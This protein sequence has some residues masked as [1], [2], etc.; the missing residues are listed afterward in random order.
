[1][2]ELVIGDVVIRAGG[3][4]DGANLQ[5]IIRAVRSA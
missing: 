3:D 5:R 2:I 1:M 4:F